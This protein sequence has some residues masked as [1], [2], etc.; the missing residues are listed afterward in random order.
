MEKDVVSP[1]KKYLFI[2]NLTLKIIGIILMTLNHIGLFLKSFEYTDLE[3]L[4]NLFIY[5]GSLAFPI[6]VFL[7]ME[8]VKNTS[9]IKKYLLRMLL[10]ALLIYVAI[11]ILSFIPGF[12][13]TYEVYKFGNI[14]I[15]LSLFILLYM[16]FTSTKNFKFASFGIAT[17]YVLTYL[18][19]INIIDLTSDS[20]S[21]IFYKIIGGLM[22][23]YSLFGLLLFVSYYLCLYYYEKR[24][25]KTDSEFRNY[26]NSR[27]LLSKNIIYCILLA[28]FSFLFYIF[29]YIGEFSL[30]VDN[31]SITYMV[32]ASIFIAFYN[33]ERKG[34]NSKILKYSFYLYYPLHLVILFLIF[35]LIGG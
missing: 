2:D 15:D 30:G 17:F 13:D 32:L 16:C 7:L 4:S 33:Y 10:S 22:P 14:F 21:L 24:I 8:G 1:K 29:T 31:I 6:F 23:Q 9:N 27:Y 34:K 5:I 25:D 35:Y 11:L 3:I 12:S 26:D 20:T 28:I 18:I 19:K